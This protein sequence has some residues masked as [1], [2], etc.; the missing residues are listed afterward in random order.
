[1]GITPSTFYLWKATHIEFSEC[2]ER[3]KEEIDAAL[4]A[5]AVQRALGYSYET[6]KAF[7]TGVVV[8]ITET[9]P[10]SEKM[11]GYLLER[12]IPDKYANRKVV[13]HNHTINEGLRACMEE[14]VERSRLRRAERAKLI[15]RTNATEA[16]G[17]DAWDSPC[18]SRE[19]RRPS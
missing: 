12:R 5:T 16:E 8:T 3:S 18:A 11:L 6:Q 14:M 4:E 15:D 10:P 2:L 7:Q 13:D 17:S 1:M 9:L 19:K